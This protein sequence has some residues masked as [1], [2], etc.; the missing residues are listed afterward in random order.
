MRILPYEL[1]KYSPDQSLCALRKEFGIYDYCLNQNKSNKAMNYFLEKGR[2]YFNL[3][4]FLWF[5]E[6]KK[7][8]H[9]MN[10]FHIFY[11]L[12]NRY[13]KKETDLFLILECCIQWDIKKFLPYQNNLTWCDIFLLIYESRNKNK[14]IFHQNIYNELLSWY[15]INFIRNN[16]KGLLKPHQLNMEKVKKHFQKYL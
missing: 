9:Y 11:A 13:D 4:F 12:N 1:Y 10:S 6:M 5:E 2:N 14:K 16:Q 3:S 7:R 8:K 15:K